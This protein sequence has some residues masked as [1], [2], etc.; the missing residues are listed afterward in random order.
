[1]NLRRTSERHATPAIA[2]KLKDAFALLCTRDTSE[3]VEEEFKEC[4]SAERVKKLS[5]KPIS[6]PWELQQPDRRALDLA[7]FELLGVADAVER[8][9]LCDELYRETASHFRQIRIVE[10]QKQEER[11]GS[12]GREFRTDELAADLWDALA[13]DEREPLVAWL[14][15]NT[16]NG[17]TISLPD[18]TPTLP[19]ATDMFSASSLFF[20]QSSGSKQLALPSRAHAELVHRL[21]IEGLHGDLHLPTSES[22]ATSLLARLRDRLASLTEKAGQLSGSRTSDSAHATDLAGLLRQWMI[23]GKPQ[24]KPKKAKPTVV[25]TVDGTGE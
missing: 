19:D 25:A 22:D 21:A 23:H 17:L 5:A 15:R 12:E 16:D 14:A 4:R 2:K 7:V 20:R 3:L 6:L 10:I 24:R 1:M 18:G 8:D 13:E 9:R 11:A